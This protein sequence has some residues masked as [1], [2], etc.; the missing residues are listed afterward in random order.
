VARGWYVRRATLVVAFVLTGAAATVAWAA[1]DS[2][3]VFFTP[4][5][6]SASCEIDVR[7]AG[8]ATETW[9]GVGPP[10]LPASRA[11]GVTLTP[12]GKLVVC[13]GLRCV[14]NAPLSTPMLHH[15]RSVALGPFH[16]TSLRSGVRCLVSKLG[17]GFVLGARGLTRI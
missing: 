10:R 11:I 13:H 5:P 12:S 14:G 16:C 7:V 9:C 3:R 4:G 1:A 17:H 15:G 8:L 6:N 2:Q